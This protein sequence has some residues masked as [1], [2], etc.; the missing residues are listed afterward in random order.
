MDDDFGKD[1]SLGGC[2][3]DL[4][5]MPLSAQPTLVEKDIDN[6]KGGGWFSKT[7]TA[8]LELSFVA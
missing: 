3:I 4:G 8:H 7:A 2:T 5:N 1:D 6:K